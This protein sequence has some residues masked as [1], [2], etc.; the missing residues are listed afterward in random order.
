M[1]FH[2][3]L[4]EVLETVSQ[5]R[6]YPPGTTPIALSGDAIDTQDLKARAWHESLTPAQE[7]VCRWVWDKCGQHYEPWERF[8]VGFL[9]DYNISHELAVW[10][11]IAM[12]FAEFVERHPSVNKPQVIGELCRLSAGGPVG[13]LKGSRAKELTEL[14]K[15]GPQDLPDCP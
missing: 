12:V 6:Q 13:Q 11:R 9:Y 7:M 4:K 3:A 8:E 15:Q 1:E 10:V 5:P 14:W 2:E